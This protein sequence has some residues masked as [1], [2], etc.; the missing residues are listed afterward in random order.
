[1]LKRY[2][3]EVLPRLEAEEIKENARS[4]ACDKLLNAIT[5]W[6]SGDIGALVKQ[7]EDG[8]F[9]GILSAAG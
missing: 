6:S 1:M 8:A 2:S 4:E 9:G 7:V 3:A 5:D